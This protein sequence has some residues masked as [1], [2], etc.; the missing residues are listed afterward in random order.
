M[1][2][3]ILKF[4]FGVALWVVAHTICGKFPFK[5]MNKTADELK[6]YDYFQFYS[7]IYMVVFLILLLVF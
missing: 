7:A 5:N 1:W 2:I 4:I 3:N 6:P